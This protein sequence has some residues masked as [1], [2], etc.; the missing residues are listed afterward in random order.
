[1]DGRFAALFNST[2]AHYD[3]SLFFYTDEPSFLQ[4]MR[5]DVDSIVV[6]Q[7]FPDEVRLSQTCFSDSPRF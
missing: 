7:E 4:Q 6:F 1:M 3:L 5:T 2:A